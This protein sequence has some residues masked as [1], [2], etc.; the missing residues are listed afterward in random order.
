M[1]HF[2]GNKRRLSQIGLV[3]LSIF[4]S[5][6]ALS[7]TQIASTAV[8]P[9]SERAAE[10]TPDETK[11][12]T[13]VNK[14]LTNPISTIWSLTFQ[15]NTYWLHPGIGGVGS[16]NQINI[17]FQ[18]VLPLS[19]NDDWNL[20]TRPVLQVL[21]SSPYVNDKGN[22]H[23]VTGFGDTIFLT[24]LSPTDRLV[25]NWLL[26]AGPTVVLPTASNQRLGADKWQLG[27]AGVF[28]HLGERFIAGGVSAAVVVGR[29]GGSEYHQQLERPV[30]C[31]VFSPGRLERGDFAQPVSQ[32]VR[33]ARRQHA[34]FSSRCQYR[35]GAKARNFAGAIR[36]PR[37]AHARA[38][39]PVRTNLADS[40][41]GRAG[42]SE[43]DQ[44]RLV[45]RLTWFFAFRRTSPAPIHCAL[46]TMESSG[47]L[48]I[49]GVFGLI[50]RVVVIL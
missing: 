47:C 22:F 17:Q 40:G 38:A 1:S 10:R 42:H 7:H 26:A 24:M 36:G 32:L 37:N 23:R 43:V 44:G 45:L 18:P 27:P 5:P 8:S 33:S 41:R 31:L 9:A 35:Q 25:G 21:N 2:S 6:V 4:L 11:S 39:Q 50:Q 20:I 30:F 28:G 49:R 19:L 15:E 29:R 14:E 13:E 12:L 48:V 16:R 34:D 3:L 46:Q